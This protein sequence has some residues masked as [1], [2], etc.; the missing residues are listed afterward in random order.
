[1]R[2]RSKLLAVVAAASLSVGGVFVSATAA[3]AAE[4]LPFEVPNTTFEAYDTT[5]GGGIEFSSSGWTPGAT[6]ELNLSVAI[7]ENSGGG[8]VAEFV[9][10]SEGN[11]AGVYTPD[12]TPYAPSGSGYPQHTLYAIERGADAIVNSSVR[13]PLT[14][15]PG[16]IEPLP[17]IE[18][19]ANAN[20]PEGDTWGSGIYITGT[21]WQAESS[22]T[23]TVQRTNSDDSV[24]EWSQEVI[25]NSLGSFGVI[26][27]PEGLPPVAPDD[28]GF[29]KYTV[30]AEQVQNGEVVHSNEISL[31]IVPSDPGTFHPSIYA[32]PSYTAAE[33]MDEVVIPFAGFKPNEDILFTLI[34]VTEDGDVTLYEQLIDADDQGGGA[35]YV[36][37]EQVT[38]S[39]TLKLVGVGQESFAQA[40]AQFAVVLQDD[41]DLPG[42]PG[43]PG[44]SDEDP[45]V[46]GELAATGADQN[47]IATMGTAAAGVILLGLA[48]VVAMNRRRIAGM[49]TR[50]Q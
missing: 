2:I 40:Q 43:D 5:W 35:L 36:W 24:D 8:T 34:E 15:V 47:A 38:A 46:G 10:D 29:P 7:T 31:L 25:T 12:I 22:I 41:P 17:T 1:M 16:S 39:T 45:V 27:N 13:V 48:L 4:D 49:F 50:E 11:I 9:A 44:D 21:E 32:E 20:I 19:P 18:V 28:E 30:F 37:A 42:D 26:A 6:V 3:T 14:I 23:V 33:L